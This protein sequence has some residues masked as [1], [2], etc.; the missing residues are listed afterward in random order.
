MDE[1]TNKHIGSFDP[2]FYFRSF[3]MF[4][5]DVINNVVDNYDLPGVENGLLNKSGATTT[6]EYISIVNQVKEMLIGNKGNLNEVKDYLLKEKS[7]NSYEA[8]KVFRIAIFDTN[9][10]TLVE[11]QGLGDN[12]S[13]SNKYPDLWQDMVEKFKDDEDTLYDFGDLKFATKDGDI[14]IGELLSGS[15]EQI[16]AFNKLVLAGER[17][18]DGVSE[19]SFDPDDSEHFGITHYIP[20]A[21]SESLGKIP[22]IY[23]TPDGGYIF[24]HSNNADGKFYIAN[25]NIERNFNTKKVTGIN[26]SKIIDTN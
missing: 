7:F 25:E 22:A 5:N 26:T 15:K 9:N 12:V 24:G 23:Q 20:A 2:D 6:A 19:V 21:N 11:K 16:E 13:I 18:V 4:D 3:E 1:Q 8:M 14:K 10:D 17:N